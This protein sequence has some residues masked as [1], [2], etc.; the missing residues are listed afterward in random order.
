[1]DEDLMDKIQMTRRVSTDHLHLPYAGAGNSA[2]I[3]SIDCADR[4]HNYNYA[5]GPSSCD[6]C[7][8]S[9]PTDSRAKLNLLASSISV[10]SC[11]IQFFNNFSGQV[12][13][14]VLCESVRTIKSNEMTF[15]F[16]LQV[17]LDTT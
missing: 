5:V 15:A 4:H 12:V 9:L 6:H 13:Q 16:G 11:I 1:M 2:T 10:F 14:L 17:H 8:T 3:S 7:Q